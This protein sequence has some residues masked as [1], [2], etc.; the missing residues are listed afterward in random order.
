MYSQ[1]ALTNQAGTLSFA[2]NARHPPK[3]VM[4]RAPAIASASTKKPF[5]S[6]PSR[7]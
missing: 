2:T 4:S 7:S 3:L 1:L 6:R 5:T